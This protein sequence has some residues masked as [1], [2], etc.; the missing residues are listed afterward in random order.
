MYIYIFFLRG[1]SLF[2]VVLRISVEKQI[3]IPCKSRLKD[4]IQAVC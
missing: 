2:E 4:E 3:A 1:S